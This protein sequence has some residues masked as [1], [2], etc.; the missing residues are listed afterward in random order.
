M[1]WNASVSVRRDGNFPREALAQRAERQYFALAKDFLERGI[2]NNPERWEMH[3]ALAFFSQEK[4]RDHC[5]AAEAYER[6]SQFPEAPP[7]LRRF[8][9]Y[10]LAQCDGMEKE[11]YEKLR[12][13]FLEGEEQRLPTLVTKLRELEKSLEIPPEERLIK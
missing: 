9:G 12:G 7:H 4:L 8:A 11:A 1:G 2:E 3:Q 6:A 13:L 10:Q 5:A